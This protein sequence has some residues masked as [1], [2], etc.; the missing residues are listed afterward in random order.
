MASSN[1]LTA[2]AQAGGRSKGNPIKLSICLITYNRAG[3][4]DL[5]LQDLFRVRPFD[6]PFEVVL[7]D[8][9]S[10]DN[11]PE[12]VAAWQARQPEIRA[13]RQKT[14]VG[15]E[16]N[17]ATAYRLAKGEFAVY[18]ADDDRL[19]PEG[20]AKIISYMEARAN[21][22]VCH[23]G[24]QTWDDVNKKVVGQHFTVTEEQVFSKGA[25]VEM[26]NLV[27]RN[28]IY[29]EICVFRTAAMQRMHTIS[30]NVYSPYVHLAHILDYGD[31]AFVPWPFYREVAY[32]VIP[33]NAEHVGVQWSI[34]RRDSFLGGFEYLAQKA[35]RHVG[36]PGVPAAQV[37][38]LQQMVLSFN[39]AQL[40]LCV[41][42]LTSIK[43]YRG[44][45]EFMVRQQAN[46]Q[47]DE[48]Q[49]AEMRTF[50]MERA[51]VQ[52]LLE[53]FEAISVLEEVGLFGIANPLQTMA[54]IREQ[55]PNLQVKQ[56]TADDLGQVNHP[57]RMLVLMGSGGDRDKLIGAGFL[58]GLVIDESDLNRLFLL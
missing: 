27:M 14:N 24:K 51:S 19:I 43:N 35:F 53:T 41:R 44:A 28:R 2:G 58:P 20:V 7:C 33:S 52:G 56:L 38:A 49:A 29:P 5:V 23:A 25:A 22:A 12:V 36:I 3:Y 57:E 26:F 46:G 8:N 45:Y 34:H 31:V 40:G 16:N 42:L 9:H 21:I 17:I 48:A 55:R 15:H 11:T 50:L 4:L 1:A 54:L 32:G 37:G 47:C 30:F 13:M 10:T 6:F 18:L 39:V